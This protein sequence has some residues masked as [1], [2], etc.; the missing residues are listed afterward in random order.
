V[1]TSQDFNAQFIEG[2]VTA[3][4]AATF[5]GLP[6]YVHAIEHPD[7]L[8][9]VDTGMLDSTPELDREGAPVPMPENIPRDVLC[10]I[11]THLHFDHCGGNRLFP[12]VPIHVQRLE[13]HAAHHPHEWVNFPDAT[14]IEHDGEAEVLPG[15]RLLPTPGHTPGHQSVLVDTPDGLI[16]IGGDVAY[17]FNELE[18]GATEGQRRVLALAA[19]TWLTHTDGGPKLPRPH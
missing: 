4:L 12:G 14:Y 7:G 13:L 6:V 5:A 8:V 2:V 9:L 3:H 15:I 1:S 16:V 11:N 10:V 17:T 19:P 18:N